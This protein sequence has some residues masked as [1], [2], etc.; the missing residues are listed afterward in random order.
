MRKILTSFVLSFQLV[1]AGLAQQLPPPPQPPKPAEQKPVT[2]PQEDLDVVKITTNLVQIDAVV[3]DS[4]GKRVT[5]LR[6]DEVEMLENGKPQAIT[7]FSYIELGSAPVARSTTKNTDRG[8]VPEPPRRLR[9]EEVRR[10]I[11][12]VVDDLG[13]SFES[14][15]FMRQALKKFL[16]QQMQP[17]DLVAIIRTA[18][19]IGAL[20][21]FTSD[22][23]QLYAAVEKVKWQ[24]SGRGGISAFAPI[25]GSPIPP[26]PGEV[27]PDGTTP[28]E[29]LE[30]FREDLFAVGT[31]GALSYVVRGLR[32]LPGR[33]SIILFS[34]GLK[35]FSR[36]EPSGSSRVI[37]ALSRLVDSANRAAVV[38]NTMDARGLPILGLTAADSTANMN[39]FEIERRL[40]QRRTDFFHS[41]DGM[42]YLAVQTGGLAIRNTNDLSGG[43]RR[44]MEDQSGY[45]L[46]GY[47]PDDSTFDLVKGRTKFNRLSL[48]VKRSGKYKIRMRSG[49]FGVTDENLQPPTQTPQQQLV[50]ALL[51]PFSASGV[52]MRLT[53]LFANDERVGSLMRSFLHV[54]ASDLTFT[55][56]PDGTHKA[57][58][59][60]LVITFGDN[61]VIVDQAGY[62]HTMRIKEDSYGRVMKGGLTYHVT[63][64][65]KKPGA[66]QLRTALRDRESG[67][68]GSASQFINVPE[69][70]KDRLTTSGLLLK[71]I[72]FEQYQ[73]SFAAETAFAG[74][75][76]NAKQDQDPLATA[77]V[78][79]F[80]TGTALLYAVVIYNAKIDK[81]TGMP[82][83]KTQVRLF[84][85]GELIFSGKEIP[86]DK[87]TQTDL[88]RLGTGGAISLG[89]DMTPGEYVFQIVVTD[90]L[91]SEKRR[92]S[93]QWMDFEVVK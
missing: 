92:V 34:D 82:Q 49:F 25:T 41:Q 91:A 90:L 59:D 37:N 28:E 85:N 86:F 72:P 44:V 93:T 56:E 35:I 4:N 46:I 39:P 76:D 57:E 20:Q 47:R 9:P 69:F 78:R 45:Y 87:T 36:S 74:D 89:T 3:T 22:K 24:P 7:N 60:I 68:V 1:T 43:I 71:A 42:D 61:G 16:D 15:H 55:K 2:P 84:R 54:K 17:N 48:K 13:M 80:R 50:S 51:S 67:R 83:L 58:F 40:S 38:I 81:A 73:K 33:K 75:G 62:T 52:Q 64:P 21:Q 53:S 10:T 8:L 11:A 31:L 88:R 19:G 29:D 30:Q 12:L 14:A 23:R 79:Q 63:V 26:P 27:N 77:A 6:A 70:K 66:Y 65:V 32:E 5:D 18:G